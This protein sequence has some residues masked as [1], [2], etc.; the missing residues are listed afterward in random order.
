MLVVYLPRGR[1]VDKV[2]LFFDQMSKRIVRARLFA[3]VALQQRLI[4]NGWNVLNSLLLH[5]TSCWRRNGRPKNSSNAKLEFLSAAI[6]TGA[7][8]LNRQ[9]RIR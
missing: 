3:G 8:D 2:D 9:R 6:Q 5:A 4:I 7:I 1:G